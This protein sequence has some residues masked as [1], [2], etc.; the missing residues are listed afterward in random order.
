MPKPDIMSQVTSGL[1]LAALLLLFLGVA[2]L[3]FGGV[4][5]LC[6]PG[7]VDRSSF[8]GRHASIVAPIFLGV[9]LTVMIATMNRWVKVL[10]GL[11]ALAVLNGLLSISTGHLLANPTQPISRVDALYMTCFFAAAAALAATLKGRRLNLVDRVSV[12]AFVFSFACLL[13]YSGTRDV[14][15]IAPLDATDFILMGIGLCCLLIAWAYDRIQR[16]RSHKQRF[17]LTN[18]PEQLP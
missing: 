12:L 7:A 15:K 4:A 5:A 18:R 13:G 16:R 11:M 6:F 2:G 17:A 9:S 14:G 3:F 10:T 1:R 8:V